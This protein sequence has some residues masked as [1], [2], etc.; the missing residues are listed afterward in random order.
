MN[1]V[2]LDNVLRKVQ[3]P[4]ENLSDLLRYTQIIDLPLALGKQ[5]G[6]PY[7]RGR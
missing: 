7:F 6:E 3:D 4:S 2:A 5:W 1:G